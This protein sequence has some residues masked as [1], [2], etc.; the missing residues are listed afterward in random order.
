MNKS[1]AAVIAAFVVAIIEDD[2]TIVE[3]FGDIFPL[4]AQTTD[5][6]GGVTVRRWTLGRNDPGWF[7]K[8]AL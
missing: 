2:H 6:R 5:G 7:F 3:L 1:T 8:Y 4:I